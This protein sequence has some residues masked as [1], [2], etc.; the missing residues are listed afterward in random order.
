MLVKR[1]SSNFKGMIANVAKYTQVTRIEAFRCLVEVEL[2]QNPER[3]TSFLHTLRE[4]FQLALLEQ[5]SSYCK[6]E[7]IKL[8]L[9]AHARTV[10]V[11]HPE[12]EDNTSPQ[13]S[14]LNCYLAFD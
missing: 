7:M 13:V 6:R 14:E 12:L 1:G 9:K 2:I 10:L 4:I 5:N 3:G 8:L 11:K